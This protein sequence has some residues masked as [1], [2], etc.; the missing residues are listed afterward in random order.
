[1]HEVIASDRYLQKSVYDRCNHSSAGRGHPH[2]AQLKGTD[3]AQSNEES[4]Q[5]VTRQGQEVR[6][7]EEGKEVVE[8]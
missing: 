2:G 8:R 7:Q 5:E 6:G 3:N 1:V 4:R